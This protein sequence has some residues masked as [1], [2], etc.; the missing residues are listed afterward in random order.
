MYNLGNEELVESNQ[1]SMKPRPPTA[2]CRL[3]RDG[4]S[5]IA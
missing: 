5:V 2:P 4:K 3:G 1:E